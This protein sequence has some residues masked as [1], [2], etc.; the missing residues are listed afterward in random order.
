MIGYRAARPKEYVCIIPATAAAPSPATTISVI[1]KPFRLS[2]RALFCVAVLGQ[3]C[4]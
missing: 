4:N 3:S 1:A 2:T